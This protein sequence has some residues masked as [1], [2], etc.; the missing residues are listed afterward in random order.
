MSKKTR[1]NSSS[2]TVQQGSGEDGPREIA[3]IGQNAELRNS[4]AKR[5]PGSGKKAAKSAKRAEPE[6]P[7]QACLEAGRI[8]NGRRDARMVGR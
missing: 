4:P 6:N 5:Q 3:C 1:K 2:K 8:E 7:A